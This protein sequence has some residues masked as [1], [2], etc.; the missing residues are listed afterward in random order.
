MWQAASAPPVG[1]PNMGSR[2]GHQ[3]ALGPSPQ[4]SAPAGRDGCAPHHSLHPKY[5]KYFILRAI[6]TMSAGSCYKSSGE[7]DVGGNISCAVVAPNYFTRGDK[8]RTES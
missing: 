7:F 2:L 6:K 8:E 5:L 4:K 1:V 3:R